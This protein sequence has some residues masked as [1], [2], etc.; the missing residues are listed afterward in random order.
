[1]RLA[2]VVQVALVLVVTLLASSEGLATGVV[3]KKEVTTTSTTSIVASI[4]NLL[5]LGDSNPS[6][7]E[8]TGLSSTEEERYNTGAVTSGEGG[9]TGAGVTGTTTS[10]TT[11]GGT[12]TVT[13]YWNDGL[14]QRFKRWWN[15]LF[16]HDT[17]NSKRRLRQL[18]HDAK[19]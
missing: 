15:D 10:A 1:M 7:P 8:S 3:G 12:V 17:T 6:K 13:K 4:R 18:E 16:H 11:T 5:A 14:L 2:Q 19:E 9:R